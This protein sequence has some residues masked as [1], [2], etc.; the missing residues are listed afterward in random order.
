MEYMKD[1]PT[2]PRFYKKHIKLLQA[3]CVSRKIVFDKTITDHKLLKF[4]LVKDLYGHEV[5]ALDKAIHAK[6]RSSDILKLSRRK[7]KNWFEAA[8][9]VLIKAEQER[10]TAQSEWLSRKEVLASREHKDRLS[11]YEGYGIDMDVD[12]A[13]EDDK[14]KGRKNVKDDNE[15]EEDSDRSEAPEW[16]RLVISSRI[17]MKSI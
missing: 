9:K 5:N 17:Y 11:R 10:Y 4:G 7:Q 6:H 3:A 14:A 1:I 13:S 15:D 8:K 2:V 12:S 16:Q